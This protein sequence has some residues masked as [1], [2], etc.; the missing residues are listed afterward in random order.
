M[1]L[2]S[3]VDVTII[4]LTLQQAHGFFDVDFLRGETIKYQTPINPAIIL[5]RTT[6]RGYDF[7]QAA[8]CCVIGNIEISRQ[9][10]DVATVLDEQFDKIH[11]LSSQAAN[12]T[13]A[14]LPLNH[15][16]TLWTFQAGDDQL[17]ATYR[18]PCN[19]WMHVYA[20]L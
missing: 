3:S 13:Q 17:I 20:P 6:Q 12:P 11:L 16:T 4:A 2:R 5:R 8:T 19:K 1:R 15:D 10:L 18:V 7:V 14:K 9:L